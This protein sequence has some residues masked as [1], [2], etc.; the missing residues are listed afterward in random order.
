MR[1]SK[2]KET[3]SDHRIDV[4][5]RQ[6]QYWKDNETNLLLL[7]NTIVLYLNLLFLFYL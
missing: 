6:I 3:E 4:L 1:V 7:Y 2:K 5:L